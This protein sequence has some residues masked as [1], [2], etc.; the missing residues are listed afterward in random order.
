MKPPLWKETVL[1][2]ASSG[3][4]ALIGIGLPGSGKT[5]ILKPLAEEIG[6]VYVNRDD[7]REEL[8]G[9]PTDHTKEPVVSD[10]ASQKISEGLR[11][12]KHIVVDATNARRRDRRQLTNLIRQ[13]EEFKIVGLYVNTDLPTSSMRNE[14]REKRVPEPAMARMHNRLTLNLPSPEEGFDSVIVTNPPPVSNTPQPRLSRRRLYTKLTPD[15]TGLARLINLQNLINFTGRFRLTP[16]SQLHLTLLHFG[17]IDEMYEQIHTV[18]GIDQSQYVKYLVTFIDRLNDALPDRP[19]TLL[20]T[21]V[22]VFGYRNSA[23]VLEFEPTQDMITAHRE[24]Y[25]AL[26][27]FLK[28]CDVTD[29]ARFI[30]KTGALRHSPVLTPHVTL[31]R[32]GHYTT[33]DITLEEITFGSV[34]L[35]IENYLG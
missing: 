27:Q 9:N 8:T 11:A 18:T 28:D 25:T 30:A 34:P 10:I 16:P 23:I 35:S 7:I 2:Y 29:P 21:R 12:K 4:L 15:D 19:Q 17:L 1:A 3:P 22:S 26:L 13:F 32:G 6:A 31:S 24:M 14:A 20:P 33:E 5:T